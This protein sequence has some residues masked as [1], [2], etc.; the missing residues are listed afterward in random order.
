MK[1]NAPLM[2]MYVKKSKMMFNYGHITYDFFV[3]LL[4][5][6]IVSE[7]RTVVAGE[8]SAKLIIIN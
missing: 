4:V 7:A 5:L 1:F 6:P 8:I 2:L 3:F